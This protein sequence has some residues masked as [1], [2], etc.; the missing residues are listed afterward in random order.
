MQTIIIVG[1]SRTRIINGRLVTPPGSRDC[2]LWIEDHGLESTRPDNPQS[3][4]RNPKLPGPPL[5]GEI[6]NESFALIE[7]ELGPHSLPAWAFAVVRRMIHASADFDFARNL[8]YSDDFEG[9]VRK[10]L[11]ERV[12]VVTDTEMVLLGIRTAL[13]GA[14]SVTPACHLNEPDTLAL[15]ES[16]GLTRS[17]AGIRIA[18]RHYPAPLLLIGNAPTAL[19]EALRLVEEEGWRPLAIIAMPVGFVG[20]EEAKERLLRQGKV[21]YLSCV[22]RKGGSAVTAAAFNALCEC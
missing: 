11:S 3:E 4:I 13:A 18:A 19:D 14:P 15:A 7:R 16:A 22:G 2:G 5:A 1:N 6:M 17:A 21:P 10:A 9:A 20:V 12:P 8:R